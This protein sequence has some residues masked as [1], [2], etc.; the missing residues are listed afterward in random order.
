MGM[1]ALKELVNIIGRN[2]VKGVGTLPAEM[3]AESLK[4]NQLFDALS[5]DELKSDEGVALFLDVTPEDNNYRKLKSKLKSQLL[6][7]VFLVDLK[8]ANGTEH[9]KALVQCWKDF[10]AIKIL[11]NQGASIVPV[12]LAQRL[13]RLALQFRFTELILSTTKLMRV[14]YTTR[15]PDARKFE[16]SD[17]IYQQ[18]KKIAFAE[19]L[20]EDA[21]TEL[22]TQYRFMKKNK[23]E[24]SRQAFAAFEQVKPFLDENATHRLSRHAHMLQL[25]GYMFLNDYRNSIEVCKSAIHKLNQPPY[26]NSQML[27]IFLYQKLACYTQLKKYEEGLDVAEESLALEIPGSINWF[28][29]RELTLVLALHTQNYQHAYSI[30]EQAFANQRFK[31]LSGENAEQW[32]IVE[33]YLQFLIHCGKIRLEGEALANNFRLNK[34]LNEVPIF[35]KEKAGR[36]IPVLIVQ[37]L[38]LIANKKYEQAIFRIDALARY[39]TRHLRREDAFRSNCFIRLLQQVVVADFHKAGVMRRT[40]KFMEQLKSMPLDA[41]NQDHDIEMIPYEDLWELIVST[42]TAKFYYQPRSGEV[43]RGRKPKQ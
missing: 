40:D 33:A 32:K 13:L 12:E 38:M 23:T 2:K 4:I 25:F 39:S 10:A 6:D 3:E 24:L 19:N 18:Y 26:R 36:N 8:Q 1:E 22:I 15:M 11:L 16:Q 9:D 28:K 27:N 42:L 43:K 7:A 35:S 37:I 5:T 34:F 20:V 30:F 41:A 29:N 14:F 17:K 31:D 21:Y